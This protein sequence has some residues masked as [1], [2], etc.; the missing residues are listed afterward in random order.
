MSL[1]QRQKIQKMLRREQIKNSRIF[2]SRT[3]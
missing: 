1:R 2:L 3:R